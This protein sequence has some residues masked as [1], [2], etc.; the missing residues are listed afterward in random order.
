MLHQKISIGI[1]FL[2]RIS[3][4][5]HIISKRV[6]MVDLDRQI[7]DVT[8]SSFLICTK[9]CI[10][11]IEGRIRLS[12]V[13]IYISSHYLPLSLLKS[14]YNTGCNVKNAPDT[15]NNMV[16]KGPQERSVFSLCWKFHA[17]GFEIKFC[18]PF[19]VCG[20]SELVPHRSIPCDVRL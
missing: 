12:V 8:S 18:S 7:N 3:F 19:S 14:L 10:I 17:V 9:C 20:V 13:S 11:H 1:I 16:L 15:G 2:R 4:A 6:F 5:V